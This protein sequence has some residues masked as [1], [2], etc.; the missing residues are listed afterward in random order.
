VIVYRG[1]PVPEKR[2]KKR[3]YRIIHFAPTFALAKDFASGQYSGEGRGFIQEYELP[4]QELLRRDTAEAVGLA[5]KYLGHRPTEEEIDTLFWDPPQDW[6]DGLDEIGFT[7]MTGAGHR[8]EG[9]EVSIWN[10]RGIKLLRRWASAE[11]RAP[12]EVSS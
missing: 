6:I 12:V 8:D 10:T 2:P 9:G 7:G 5:V 4:P 3:A 11:G 1:T